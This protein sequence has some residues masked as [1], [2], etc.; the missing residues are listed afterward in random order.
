MSEPARQ[1]PSTDTGSR[2]ASG[3]L[4]DWLAAMKA[5]A[6]ASASVTESPAEPARQTAR[7]EAAR[8]EP[9]WSP[10]IVEARAPRA[11]DPDLAELMAENLMLK[12]KLDLE[13]DRQDALKAKLAEEIRA[14]RSHVQE[15]VGL[16]ESFRAERDR[17]LA[18]CDGLRAE[19]GRHEA[20]RDA[21]RRERDRATAERDA[22]QA[23]IARFEAERDTARAEG[24]LWRARAEA[25]A[26]PLFQSRR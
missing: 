13:T 25:L 2:P 10:R 4:R 19:Q 12:A 7:T 9:S 11:E 15:E 24:E 16:L 18:E 26:Q 20:E 1:Y 23:E 6:P 14:L 8:A 21:L 5:H 3:P 22:A 17:I